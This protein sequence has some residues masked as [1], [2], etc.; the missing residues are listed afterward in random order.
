MKKITIYIAIAFVSFNSFGQN[1][2]KK[3]LDQVSTK[4]KSYTNFSLGFTYNINGK[5]TKGDLS[6]QG[7][8]YVVNF[9]GFTQI[10]DGSKTYMISPSDE[11]VTVSSKGSSNAVSIS[12]VL[13][14]YTSGYSYQMDSKKNEGGKTIQYV[15]LTPTSKNS[16]I[17][18]V[19]LGIDL[20]NKNVYKKIDVLK[21]GTKNTLTINSFKTNQ[22][23]SKNH[24]TFTKSKYPNYY[25]NHLD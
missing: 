8:K 14:F 7:Q 21:N 16:D 10:Y 6:V 20:A 13:S 18:E 19:L 1:E 2:A 22:S 9:M 17:K 4:V 12:N 11:E 5:N 23:L 25:I 3:L 24:F 15:K